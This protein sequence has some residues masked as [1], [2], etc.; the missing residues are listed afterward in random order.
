MMQNQNNNGILIKWF[1]D[2]S[3]KWSFSMFF[4]I[5]TQSGNTVSFA[6]KV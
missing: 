5:G 2:G 6:I 1:M 4:F 3:V